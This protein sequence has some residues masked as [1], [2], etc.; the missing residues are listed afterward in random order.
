M[1]F[2]LAEDFD[3]PFQYFS[4]V[5]SIPFQKE[6][7]CPPPFKE[8]LGVVRLQIQLTLAMLLTM[9]DPGGLGE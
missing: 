1:T 5:D 9:A 8:G 2:C 3:P 7:F 6:T 4:F